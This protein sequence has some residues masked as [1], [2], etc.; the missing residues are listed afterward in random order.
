MTKR[1]GPGQV[2]S[3]RCASPK[4]VMQAEIDE[5]SMLQAAAWHAEQAVQRAVLK[6]EQRIARGATIEDGPLTFDAKLRMVRT[7]RVG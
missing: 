3:F 2:V 7:R 6:I 1:I 4:S 5:V